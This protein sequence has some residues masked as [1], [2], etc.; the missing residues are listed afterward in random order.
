MPDATDFRAACEP[1][2]GDGRPTSVTTVLS[3]RPREGVP[4]TDAHGDAVLER[5]YDEHHGRL[6]RLAYLLLGDTGRAEDVVQDSFVAVYRRLDRLE[7]ADLPAYLRQTVVNR[8]RSALRHLAVVRRHE[9]ESV[10]AP[11]PGADH[12]ALATERR[13]QVVDALS[14]LPRRQR[15]VVVLRYYLDLSEKDTA[16]TLGISQGAV[17][18]HASRGT[19]RLRELLA[20]TEEDR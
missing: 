2:G 6:V 19:A 17:K 5:V 7:G 12:D 13:G 18:S 10:A 14:R 1:R 9:Q 8:A 3:A 4:I 11:Y 20:P 15:E 16:R